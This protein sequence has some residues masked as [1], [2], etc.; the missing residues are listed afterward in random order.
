MPKFPIDAPKRKVLNA[1][2]RLGFEVV[3]EAEHIALLRRN[4]D[5]SVT[6]LTIANHPTL[7][8]GTLHR[9]LT[10]CGI[11]SAQFIK[12]YYEK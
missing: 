3:R 12:A 2:G 9:A 7:N 8:S 1:L 5:G 10:G 11:R 6:T 4:P